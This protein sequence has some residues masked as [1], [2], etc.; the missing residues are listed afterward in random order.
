MNYKKQL[1]YRNEWDE[2]ASRGTEKRVSRLSVLLSKLNLFRIGILR[3]RLLDLHVDIIVGVSF[4]YKG[5]A[6]AFI[7]IHRVFNH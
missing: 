7:A 5:I 3:N 6:I 4:P 2:E 1:D